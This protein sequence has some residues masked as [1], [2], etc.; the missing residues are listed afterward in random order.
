MYSTLV[1]LRVKVIKVGNSLRVAIPS[2]IKKA[3][4]VEEGDELLIDYDESSKKVT[5]EK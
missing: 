4:G 2:E 1:K 5:L 3:A